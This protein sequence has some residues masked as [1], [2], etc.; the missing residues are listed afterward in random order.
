MSVSEVWG[1]IRIMYPSSA[2]FGACGEGSQFCIALYPAI[3]P[4]GDGDAGAP[5]ITITCCRRAGTARLPAW[6]VWGETAVMSRI[7]P[8]ASSAASSGGIVA[9]SGMYSDMTRLIF[10]DR[11]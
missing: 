8:A 9:G 1:N 11:I 10:R 3:C 4:R 6:L 7:A 2:L 5:G